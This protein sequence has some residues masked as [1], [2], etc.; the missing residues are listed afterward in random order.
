MGSKERLL[1]SSTSPIVTV[2][3]PSMSSG[4]STSDEMPEETKSELLRRTN[5]SSSIVT[6]GIYIL[7]LIRLCYKIDFFV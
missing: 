2:I 4:P 7:A 1:H 3:S 5:S 6:L